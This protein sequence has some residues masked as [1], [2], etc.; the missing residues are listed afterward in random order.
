MAKQTMST[1]QTV[2][3]EARAHRNLRERIAIALKDYNLTIMEWALLGLVN[4]SQDKGVSVSDLARILDVKTALTS[5]MV[6]KQVKAGWLE[7]IPSEVDNRLRYVK[8]TSKGKRNVRVVELKLRKQLDSLMKDMSDE[9]V[10]CY[11]RITSLF[12]Q[13]S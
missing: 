13:L 1:F 4:D 8:L 10:N 11:C 5:V 7:K 12:A 3:I 6:S 2:I 9:D